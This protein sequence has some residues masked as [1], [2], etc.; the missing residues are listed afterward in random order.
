MVKEWKGY[1][2]TEN[3]SE[4]QTTSEM[5][6][7]APARATCILL[8]FCT[9]YDWWVPEKV[10]Q[11]LI[12]CYKWVGGRTKAERSSSSNYK[13]LEDYH[14]AAATTSGCNNWASSAPGAT[15]H[16]HLLFSNNNNV[17]QTLLYSSILYWAMIS[18]FTV[19]Y[20]LRGL[21]HLLLPNICGSHACS[22]VGYSSGQ[23]WGWF[24]SYTSSGH[25]IR[26]RDY[27]L[28]L[29]RCGR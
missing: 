27:Q 3:Q 22:I 4:Q 19:W 13:I 18:F 20:E 8:T 7:Y 1:T 17:R 2:L 24:S 15:P 28:A 16:S 5:M 9:I 26:I 6:K 25:I 21:C 14:A 11:W 12:L 23:G 10:F 29:W